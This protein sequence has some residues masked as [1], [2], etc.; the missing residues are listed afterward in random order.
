[1]RRGNVE[2]ALKALTDVVTRK[3]WT[4]VAQKD[5]QSGKQLQISD[6]TVVI[7]VVCF[8]NGNIQVQGKASAL[9]TELQEWCEAWKSS[10]PSTNLWDA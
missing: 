3:Q 8:T 1:M 10:T 9:K 7:P 6:G 2:T 5:V 4:I